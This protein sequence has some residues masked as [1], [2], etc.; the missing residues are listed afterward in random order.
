MGQ[1]HSPRS[2]SKVIAQGNGTRPQSK[3]TVQGQAQGN[4]RPTRSQSEVMAQGHRQKPWSKV[5]NQ[6][7]KVITFS[8]I[9]LGQRCASYKVSITV[10]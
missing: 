5:I 1:D 7:P 3:V 8:G 2:W 10:K 6:K 4:V 9:F